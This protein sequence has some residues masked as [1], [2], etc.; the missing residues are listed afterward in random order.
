MSIDLSKATEQLMEKNDID[1]DRARVFSYA[2]ESDDV[3]GDVVRKAISS[4]SG[5][6]TDSE[7]NKLVK[8]GGFEKVSFGATVQSSPVVFKAGNDF[9]IWG[10][11]SVEV[12]DKE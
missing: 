9:V 2:D 1:E 4:T 3:D 12:V 8:S 11:A 10:A 5:P 6:F 7:R